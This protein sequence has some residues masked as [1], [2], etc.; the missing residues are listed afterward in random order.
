[1]ARIRNYVECYGKTKPKATK[2]KERRWERRRGE[3]KKGRV[4]GFCGEGRAENG[5]KLDLPS[6]TR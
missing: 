5:Q 4:E 2:G 3:G 6:P 1:M